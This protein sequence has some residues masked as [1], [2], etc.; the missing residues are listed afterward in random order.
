MIR[1]GRI[2]FVVLA[3]ISL[4]LG[5]L[6]GLSRIG[7]NLPIGNAVPHHGVIMVG[8]FLGTL[9]TLEKI[10]PLKEG[11]LYLIPIASGSSVLMFLVGEP[12]VAMAM[13]VLASIAM[14][15]VTIVYLLRV[16]S[17]VYVVM[18]AG[19]LSW[20]LGNIVL[21]TSNFYP[22][23]LS[24]WMCFA[25]FII[26]SERLELMKFL[27][28][29]S[30]S[31]AILLFALFCFGVG[32]ALSF[33]GIGRY[34]S[35]VSLAATAI[36]LLRFDVLKLLLE[37]QGQPRFMAISLL[38][39]YFSLLLTA[40]FI[41]AMGEQL[42]SYDITVHLF[43]IGFVFSMIFA[44]GPVIL[45]GVLGI[46]SKPYGW[47]LYLWLIALH[48]SLIARLLGDALTLHELRKYSGILTALSIVGYFITIV[49]ILTTRPVNTKPV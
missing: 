22:A 47:Q 43:F 23:A 42:Y 45:P 36:W 10:I 14:V 24:W 41:V 11:Y 46:S 12:V 44:H 20:L 19:S 35:S 17:I 39:G 49:V 40:V 25:L 21:W 16:R 4:I 29:S 31:K 48:V 28:V 9:I 5:L 27:P 33:H 2:P 6:A 26:T 8:G 34:I 32:G 7:W 18:L 30:T 1:K 13:L 15:A 37:K 38:C 3:I